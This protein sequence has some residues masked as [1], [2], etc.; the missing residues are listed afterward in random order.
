MAWTAAHAVAGL[1]FLAFVV[2]VPPFSTA[3]SLV[4]DGLGAGVL[5]G[6]GQWLVLRWFLPAVRWWLPATVVLSPISWYSSMLIAF[7]TVNL[8]GWL[9]GFYSAA[10]QMA[11]LVVAYRSRRFAVGLA[12]AY[13]MAAM[14][15]SLLFYYGFELAIEGNFIR[16]VVPLLVGSAGFGAITGVVI[17]LFVWLMSRPSALPSSTSSATHATPA[18]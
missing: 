3:W 13:L 9:G 12:V 17:A 16:D 2:E 1:L 8:G 5:F 10:A 18:R 15:G 7:G 4:L 6:L 11:L 14:L